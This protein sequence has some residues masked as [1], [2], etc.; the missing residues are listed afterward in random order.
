M[1]SPFK[2][3]IWLAVVAIYFTPVIIAWTRHSPRRGWV[4]VINVFAG[5]TVI[6]WIAALVMACQSRAQ[7]PVTR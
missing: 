1:N 5:W 7:E 4:T 6:G 2:L 3:L